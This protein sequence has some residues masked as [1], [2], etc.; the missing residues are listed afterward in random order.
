MVL[1]RIR[2]SVTTMMA[3][4]RILLIFAISLVMVKFYN[5][6]F[7]FIEIS[8]FTRPPYTVLQVGCLPH[9]YNNRHRHSNYY[10][11]Y[12]YSYAKE[13]AYSQPAGR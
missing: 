5:T 10:S 4:I 6:H 1:Q 3:S 7:N 12:H 9:Y 2:R 13:P 8:I 11:N